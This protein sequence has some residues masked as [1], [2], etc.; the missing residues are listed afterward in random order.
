MFYIVKKW[1]L[2][3]GSGVVWFVSHDMLAY[4]FGGMALSVCYE[5]KKPHAILSRAG[6]QG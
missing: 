2:I 3:I 1:I 4:R 6:A 5:K